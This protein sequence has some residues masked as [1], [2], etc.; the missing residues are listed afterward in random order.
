MG[1]QR[2]FRVWRGD[3]DGGDLADFDV[4]VNDGEV[5]LDE[6]DEITKA[7]AVTLP[8]QGSPRGTQS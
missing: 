7:V 1:T 6:T 3:A 5:V 4:E 2:H 8:A